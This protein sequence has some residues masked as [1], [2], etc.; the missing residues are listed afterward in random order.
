MYPR[1][2]TP[3]ARHDGCV[4]ALQSSHSSLQLQL[5]DVNMQVLASI[6]GAFIIGPSWLVVT[7][8]VVEQLPN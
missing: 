4:H 5:N 3:H 1:T 6:S 2:W 7:C 8:L